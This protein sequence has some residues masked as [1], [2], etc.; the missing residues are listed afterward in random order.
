MPN[1]G[2]I[3][4]FF[5]SGQIVPQREALERIVS[6]K[7]TWGKSRSQKVE[8]C[9]KRSKKVKFWTLSNVDIQNIKMKLLT[10]VNEMS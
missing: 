7:I 2:Q 8:T 6:K 10:T 1:I 9:E 4:I 5:N 3:S